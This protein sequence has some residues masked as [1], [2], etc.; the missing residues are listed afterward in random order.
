MTRK[1]LNRPLLKSGRKPYTEEERALAKEKN[2]ERNRAWRKQYCKYNVEKRLLW[3]AKKRAKEND[4]PFDLV[5]SD[6]IVPL[7]CPYLGIPLVSSRPRG[8]GRMDI[9]SLD[10][11]DSS[12]GYTKDNIEVI[13]WLA[14]TMKSNAS[15]E[16]L[17]HFAKTVLRRYDPDFRL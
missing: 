7:T 9:A 15:K 12:L 14:N 6:I 8:D 13:S 10:R 2:K 4:L 3:A 17:V 1:I 16:Q 11:I 5:E